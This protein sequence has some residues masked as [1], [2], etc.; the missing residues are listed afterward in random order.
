MHSNPI[1]RNIW[2]VGRN[3]GEHAKELGNAAPAAAAEPIIFLKAGSSVV[4]S[5]DDSRGAIFRLPPFSQNVHHEVEIA[6]RFDSHLEF[7][8]LTV[9]IDLTARDLQDRL[10]SQGH[11]WTLA[12]SFRNACL[13]GPL[14]ACP[15]GLDPQNIR[16]TLK[17]NGE[18][19]QSGH[20]QD[21]IHSVEKLR[22]YVTERFPVAEGDLLL[23]G[24]PAGVGPVATDDRLEAEI[25][26][27]VKANWTAARG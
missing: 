19:R 17:I 4:S 2:A 23:T 7:D 6:F 21:M 24:T 5:N 16:F 25:P 1:V 14:I 11:P 22:R 27:L 20:T 9:A 12:K 26:G 8:A 10:K 18:L 13:I 15:Q 3:Y